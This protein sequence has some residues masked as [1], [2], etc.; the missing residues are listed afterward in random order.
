MKEYKTIIGDDG[1]KYT[2][3]DTDI[4]AANSLPEPLYKA[5]LKKEEP[6]PISENVEVA[7]GGEDNLCEAIKLKVRELEVPARVVPE[8]PVYNSPKDKVRKDN[9][10]KEFLTSDIL[11]YIAAMPLLLIFIAMM[12]IKCGFCS[13]SILLPFTLFGLSI[14]SIWFLVVA[15]L[16]RT[17][18]FYGVNK[19]SRVYILRDK[20]VYRMHFKKIAKP[21]PCFNLT[22][23]L[24]T[25]APGQSLF[26]N[27]ETEKCGEEIFFSERDAYAYLHYL[28]NVEEYN[29]AYNYSQ[30]DDFYPE[31]QEDEIFKN[32]LRDR[33]QFKDSLFNVKDIL[34]KYIKYQ[35]KLL[36][37]KKKKED[38]HKEIKQNLDVIQKYSLELQ[39]YINKN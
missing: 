35:E 2:V 4:V 26:C 37:D 19:F 15:V 12:C 3:P 24:L 28:E 36:K 39:N 29:E 30:L 17:L 8:K 11:E 10:I 27:F 21:G 18:C 14:T 25:E 38:F 6:A 9:I 13:E 1:E 7:T 32:F 5:S 33:Y 20:S 34:E 16:K 31:W 22:R 23:F